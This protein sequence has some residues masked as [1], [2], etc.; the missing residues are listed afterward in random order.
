M[1]RG[2]SVGETLS[3]RRVSPNVEVLG[4]LGGR[5]GLR[6]PREASA[7]A[8]SAESKAAESDTKA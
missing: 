5:R 1:I 8:D 6:G 4:E 3:L 7:E 2:V